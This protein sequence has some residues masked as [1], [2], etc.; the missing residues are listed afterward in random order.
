MR[1]YPAVV[2]FYAACLGAIAGGN[3]RTFQRL[4]QIPVG[5]GRNTSTA[6]PELVAYYAM[7]K[8]TAKFVEDKQAW[9][10]PLSEHFARRLFSPPQDRFSNYDTEVDRLEIIFALIF[11][12]KE[13]Q[14]T[15]DLTFMPVGR[16][17]AYHVDSAYE[18]LFAEADAAGEN[19]PPLKAGLF[20]GSFD[21]LDRVK[22]KFKELLGRRPFR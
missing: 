20:G 3:W 10:Y 21:R 8:E 7:E 5:Q 13:L 18:R 6:L 15:G 19:W 17:A 2:C 12:D 1:V 14:D 11:V 22:A 16:F 9:H 4:L